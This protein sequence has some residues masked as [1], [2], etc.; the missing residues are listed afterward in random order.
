[1]HRWNIAC[2]ARTAVSW[3]VQG[4]MRGDGMPTAPG[5]LDSEAVVAGI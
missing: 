4:L 2:D 1:M 5:M 3:N